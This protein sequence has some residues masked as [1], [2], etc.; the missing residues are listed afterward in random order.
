MRN[1]KE[2]GK[3]LSIGQA[4]TL[5]GIGPQTLRTLADSQK[6]PSYRTPSGQ[7]KFD[8]HYLQ[9]MCSAGPTLPE[10]FQAQKQNFLYARV[11]SKKQ[12]DD[13]SRQVEHLRTFRAEHA[14]FVVVQDIGSGI[15][16]KRKGLQTIL[17][18]CLQRRIGKVVVTYRDRLARFAF[19][20]IENLVR[21]AGGEIIVLHSGSTQTGETELSEDLLSIIHVYCC[22]QMGRRKYRKFK[23]GLQKAEDSTE[24][25]TTENAGRVDD[26]EQL[27]I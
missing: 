19:D 8:R 10:D 2:K 16:F 7:R 6:I 15:N 22:R 26:H 9:Q 23:S 11:S 3:F 25:S 17:D 21:N 20:L 14:T 12:V 18:A 24:L 5:T 4:A 13:L 27:R 1:E